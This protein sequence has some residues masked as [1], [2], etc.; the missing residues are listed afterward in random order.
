MKKTK[1]RILE[2]AARL[3]ANNSYEAVTMN[4]IAEAVGIKAGSIYNHYEG[5][6]AILNTIYALFVERV[7]DN[8][9]T[10]EEYESILREG[11]VRDILEIVYYPLRE[12]MEIM[13]N[14]IRIV[15]GRVYVDPT[16]A[17]L[18]HQ[19]IQESGYAYACQ[20]L[21]D[22]RSFGRLNLN[23]HEINV[24]GHLIHG[25][26]IYT[27]S[28]VVADPDQAKWRDIEIDFL[29]QFARILELLGK[30]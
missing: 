8:R 16:A 26:R 27:A 30:Q 9:K 1:D 3:F 14:T 15:F 19:H 28:A 2:H 13:F 29:D 17:A 24:Y 21:T 6:E 18:Y 4:N 5:K 23:D 11:T 22:A 10:P 25:S 12:P 20:V 7:Y